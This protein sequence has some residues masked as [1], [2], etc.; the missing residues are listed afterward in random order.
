MK[1]KTRVFGLVHGVVDSLKVKATNRARAI[2]AV[3]G[4]ADVYY[5]DLS[6][7]SRPRWAVSPSRSEGLVSAEDVERIPAAI[8]EAVGLWWAARV[9]R[10]CACQ[11]YDVELGTAPD[12][13]S[14]RDWAA[15]IELTADGDIKALE[16]S[17]A[18]LEGRAPTLDERDVFA[19]AL[20]GTLWDLTTAT[21][22]D[23]A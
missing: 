16:S 8:R 20:L 13:V 9:G 21:S 12:G 7:D 10:D 15:A 22:G 23:A 1:T 6:D 11:R 19:R 17:V 3:F 4:D 18:A 2:D 14:Y 5:L